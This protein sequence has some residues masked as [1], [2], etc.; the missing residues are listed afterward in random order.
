M[1]AKHAFSSVIVLLTFAAAPYVYSFAPNSCLQY[2]SITR[3]PATAS[4]AWTLQISAALLGEDQKL[5][6]PRFLE[7]EEKDPEAT[8][9]V[10]VQDTT[11]GVVEAQSNPWCAEVHIGW[12]GCADAHA[13]MGCWET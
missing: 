12:P 8:K 7:E 2:S 4:L 9:Q 3:G 10:R 6:L 13:A 5:K 1:I 11:S